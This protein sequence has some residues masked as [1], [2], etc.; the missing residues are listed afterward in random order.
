MSCFC[1][2]FKASPDMKM[3]FTYTFI[4]MQKHKVAP[5]LVLKQAKTNS[6]FL[7][8]H[9]HPQGS[10]HFKSECDCDSFM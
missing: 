9:P 6:E 2:C 10:F 3:S 1:L 8:I 7:E 5:G 4:S